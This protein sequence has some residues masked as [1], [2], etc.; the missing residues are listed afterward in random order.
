MKPIETKE[1][2]K[3]RKERVQNSI[4]LTT[5][6]VESKKVYNRKKEKAKLHK[7]ME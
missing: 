2:P 4:P 6:I 1:T 5:K 3:S 7:E